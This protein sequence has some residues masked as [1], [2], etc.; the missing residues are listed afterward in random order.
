MEFRKAVKSDINSIM[1]IIRQAQEKLKSLEVD[2][3]QNN[4]PNYKTIEEDINNEN[5]YILL[6]DDRVIGTVAVIFGKE[7]TYDKIYHGQWLSNK[8]YITIHRMALDNAY[9]GTGLSSM[10]LKEIEKICKNK[11]IHSIKV[12]T[13]RGNLAMQKFLEKNKFQYCGII[14]LED[15]KERIAYEKIIRV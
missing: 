8:E 4:Y 5:S 3:W 14:Y 12:D 15:G 13:H 11:D 10:I 2:Q 7:K 9:K 1:N 6:E